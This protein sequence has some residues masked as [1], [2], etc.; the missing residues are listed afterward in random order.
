MIMSRKT[1]KMV[2]DSII[3][4]ALN[5]KKITRA[6]RLAILKLCR[7]YLTRRPEIEYY[8]TIGSVPSTISL[9]EDEEHPRLPGAKENKC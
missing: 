6:R 5:T 7:K 8:L 3:A 4:A 1:R 9:Y 2:Q